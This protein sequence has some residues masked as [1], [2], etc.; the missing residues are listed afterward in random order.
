MVHIDSLGRVSATSASSGG[1]SYDIFADIAVGP[2][3]DTVW[4]G[5]TQPS[6][7]R[8]TASTTL[9]DGQQTSYGG[10]FRM[11]NHISHEASDT[12]SVPGGTEGRSGPFTFT[13]QGTSPPTTPSTRTAGSSPPQRIPRGHGERHDHPE[14][15]V[16]GQYLWSRSTP[17]SSSP[18]TPRGHVGHRGEVRMDDGLGLERRATLPLGTSDTFS[19]ANPDLWLERRGHRLRLEL[20]RTVNTISGLADLQVTQDRSHSGDTLELWIDGVYIASSTAPWP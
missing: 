15:L 19:V 4:I 2:G 7:G 6:Q 13:Y 12:F 8:Q 3:G 10:L 11:F 17:G 20:E 9:S 16:G 1:Q 18:T 5:T 14:G